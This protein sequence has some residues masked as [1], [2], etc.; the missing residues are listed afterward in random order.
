MTDQQERARITP[1]PV[2][3]TFFVTCLVDQFRPQVGEAVVDVLASE[4]IDVDVPPEQTCCG[5]PAFNSG[6]REEARTVARRF[7]DL[8]D[9]PDSKQPIVAPSGSCTAMVRN[10]Y[11]VLFR[12]DPA[13]LERVKRVAGR[14]WE[15][16]EFLG[17]GL[18]LP[19]KIESVTDE[20]QGAA[21]ESPSSPGLNLMS[22]TPASADSGDAGDDSASDSQ[23]TR[24][25]AT[26]HRCCHALRELGIDRQPSELLESV[27]GLEL[28]S[29]ER[30]E[31]C[32]GFG[33]S[34][35]VK[36]PDISTAMLDEKLDNVEA[37]GAARLIAGDTGC[38]MHMEGGL[39]RRNSDIQVLHIAEFLAESL[40]NRARKDTTTATDP[41]EAPAT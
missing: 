19:G 29:L 38:I 11:P 25:T 31:V 36:M 27:E 30:S 9:H 34:F 41:S 18:G 1:R 33:G 37:T 15:F 32:C 35:S 40:K 13:E 39:R 14:L 8:F 26:Y 16:T 28:R 22:P 2:N 5:Q 21:A 4:R 6:F 20:R 10:Y 12:D 7:L 23:E 17:D 24:A 3:A